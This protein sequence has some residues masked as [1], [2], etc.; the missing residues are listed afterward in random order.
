MLCFRGAG[1]MQDKGDFV[2]AAPGRRGGEGHNKHTWHSS[3]T[4][5]IT[6]ILCIFKG[7]L[8]RPIKGSNG[9]GEGGEETRDT[10]SLDQGTLV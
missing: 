2:R 6:E 4:L 9:K 3:I 5:V 10:K 8:D 1:Q 7:Q